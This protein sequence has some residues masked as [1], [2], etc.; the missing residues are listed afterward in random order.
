VEQRT[1]PKSIGCGKTFRKHLSLD[2]KKDGEIQKWAFE[3]CGELTERLE[4]DRRENKR[5]PK[6][7]G[8]SVSMSDKARSA[9]KSTPAPREYGKYVETAT[10]LILQVVG[11]SQL[12]IAGLT[13]WVNIFVE[14]AD[15]SN[16][17]MAAFGRAPKPSGGGGVKH[18]NTRQKL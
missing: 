5:T 10:K 6:L 4:V 2:A 14:V 8:V 9:S 16:N 1:L 11:S 17:I 3:L 12:R 18:S 13:V 15:E 7:F